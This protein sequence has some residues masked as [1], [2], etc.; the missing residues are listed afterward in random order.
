MKVDK[1]L[2]TPLYDQ[3]KH[4]LEAKITSKEWDVGYQL[5]TEKK[6][7]ETFN[8]S[9]ITIKRAIHDLVHEGLLYRQSGKGTFVKTKDETN[10]TRLVSLRNE[11]WENQYHPH[12][13]LNLKAEKA[14][15][16]IKR[17][18]EMKEDEVYK[19][20]RIKL[21]EDI[22]VAIEYS[23]IP[24]HLFPGLLENDM[25]KELLYNLFTQ[26][27]HKKLGKAKVYFSIIFADSYEAALLQLPVGEQLF[28]LERYTVDEE[29]TIIEYSRFILKQEQSNFYL[30]IDL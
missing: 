12:R 13:T 11:A 8:V 14:S 3:V 29:G 18:L 30:E 1:D 16:D 9:N 22:P 5:P 19:I 27:Y 4:I 23:Y 2:S 7:A 17:K 15:S 20:H 21:R 10:L 26:T 25:E 6:L 24:V 28:S